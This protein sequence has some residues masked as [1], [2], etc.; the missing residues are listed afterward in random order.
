[1]TS[2][3]IVLLLSLL[4]IGCTTTKNTAYYSDT[5]R[6]TKKEFKKRKRNIR[7]YVGVFK[8]SK[9]QERLAEREHHG[10]L[11]N[12]PILISLLEET[13]QKKID[14]TKLLVIIYH[15]GKDPCNTTGFMETS[16]KTAIKWI[17]N[18]TKK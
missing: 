9:N 18:S 16:K 5:K 1:M 14:T 4:L 6:V 3:F 15:P 12:L 11:T 13:L 8:T 7:K 2:R 10:Q 17:K